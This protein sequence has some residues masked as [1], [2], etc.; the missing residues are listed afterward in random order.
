MKRIVFTNGLV[1]DG[2]GS[3]PEPGEVVVEGDRIVE[4]RGGW[5][6]EHGEDQVVDA[7]G[8]TVM[9]G[10][11][12]S[13]S[14]LTFPSAVGHIDTG[15]NPPL[16]VSFFG[17]IEGLEAE[18]ARAER[19]AA[20]LLDAGFTSAYSAGSLLPMPTEVILR[21]KIAAGAVPGPRL[22]AASMERDNHPVR[23]DGH[24]EPDWQGPD[25][26]RAF[27][28]EQAAMGFDSVKFLLSND[29]VFIPGGSQL[30]QYTQEEASAAG[31]A[32]R[33]C[34]V[35][36]NCHAQSAESVKIAVRAGFR[37]I[38]HCTYADEEALDLLE[39]VK[40]EIFVSPAPGIIY[41][42]VHEGEEFGID[43]ATAE[44]MGSVAALE[45]MIRIYPEIRARG[46][47]VLPGGDYGFPNNPIG[48]NAR[49]LQLFVE[50]LGF[51]PLETLRAATRY[52]GQVMGMG[53]ELGLLAP[54]Y[55]ADVL[56]VRGNPASDVTILQDGENILAIMQGGRFHKEPV[57]GASAP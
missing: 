47:R 34:G 48:R 33:E 29:D 11:V 45:G 32:A 9:P 51:T 31:E 54:G 24:V 25:A 57:P 42:N 15:F 35:W 46:I 19:N 53:D 52:G 13:H 40:D 38:Y 37:S 36:L 10:L 28:R 55:L 18:V 43:R 7:H 4:V 26:C 3:P 39:S 17:R 16:D 41:A 23:P 21:D 1:F 27:V 22:R 50:L 49:D 8:C 2:T 14:H 56:M 6:D 20:I 12:E 44:K 30:T 5:R